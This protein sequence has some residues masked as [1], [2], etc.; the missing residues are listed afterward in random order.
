MGKKFHIDINGKP[1][2]CNADVRVC[3]RGGEDLHKGSFE[4]AVQLADRINQEIS[5]AKESIGNKTNKLTDL[6]GNSRNL[7]TLSKKLQKEIQWYENVGY[8]KAYQAY[9]KEEPFANYTEDSFKKEFLEKDDGYL[10]TVEQLQQINKDKGV[11]I[12]Q[13]KQSVEIVK[14]LR[15]YIRGLSF[16]NASGTSYLVFGKADEKK[17]LQSLEEYGIIIERKE[18]NKNPSSSVFSVRI[19]DHN[20]H[21]TKYNKT[22]T[23]VSAKYKKEDKTLKNKEIKKEL[24]LL[25]KEQ[26]YIANLVRG[27][28]ASKR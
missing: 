10:K 6:F 20:K 5:E 12:Q 19:A 8:K 3:P 28:N 11:F 15:P 4:E 21:R 27:L 22:T 1:V 14:K 16:S 2:K 18:L 23:E 13:R 7:N 9:M 17:V 25:E 26:S 24:A